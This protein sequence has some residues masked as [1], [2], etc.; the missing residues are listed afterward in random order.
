MIEVCESSIAGQSITS[1]RPFIGTGKPSRCITN[2]GGLTEISCRPALMN[3]CMT[4]KIPREQI[5]QE[6]ARRVVFEFGVQQRPEDAGVRNNLGFCLIPVE[7]RKALGHLRAAA[8][9][10]YEPS[11]T[12]AYNQ[13]CCYVAIGRSR[14]A[15]NIADSE[16]KK[17]KV[18]PLAAFL[19]RSHEGQWELFL[20]GNPFHEIAV[21]AAEVARSEGWKDQEEFWRTTIEQAEH[22]ASQET[23][24]PPRPQES[25]ER[26][27]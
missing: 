6:I 5:T 15:L 22:S 27:N 1:L 14:A 3:L 19:W 18:K 26:S 25:K 16:Y 12:N 17:L 8:N 7:P 13:M 24:H 10:G 2:S 9:M 4:V 20:S 21:F 23:D 11:A